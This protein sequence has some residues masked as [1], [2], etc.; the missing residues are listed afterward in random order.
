[1][2]VYAR[3]IVMDDA[4]R[5][6]GAVPLAEGWCWFENVELLSRDAPAQVIA[7]KELPLDVL[8]RL[9]QPRGSIATLAMGAPQ[10]MGI[11][12]VTP[13]S[14]SDGGK[15]NAVDAAVARALQMV[16]EGA[17][18]IDVGGEST[19][20]G[21]A[22]VPED[23]ELQRV[24][25]PISSLRQASDVPISIDTR[26]SV[27]AT[28]AL[29]AGASMLNDVSAFTFNADMPVVAAESDAPIC[30]MHA[31][32]DPKTMQDAP[33]YDNVL[34]DI[35]DFLAERIEVAVAAGVARDRIVVDP[36]I[37]FG[38]TQEHNLTLLRNI[39]LFHGLG[40][41]ILLGA[42]RKRFIGAIGNAPDASDRLGGSVSVALFALRQGV[43][44]LRVHDTFATKQAI[45]LHMAMIGAP[46]YGA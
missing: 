31:L 25:G 24:V 37:G 5:P 15:H 21:A 35:Y 9:T 30:I 40:C 45:D 29:G 34:L 17:A 7:A 6:D 41:P 38:K 19:R 33:T 14:F 8:D 4:V 16:K 44:I 26:K 22:F 2:T 23:E 11:L 3:P 1:M 27:V 12:N 43:Q 46:G 36:G 42:S 28:K 18:L 20:P 32:G 39:S 13:D 10:V